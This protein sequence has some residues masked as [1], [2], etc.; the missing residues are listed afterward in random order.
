MPNVYGRLPHTEDARDFRARA[1]RP[2]TGAY[3]NLENRFGPPLDQG[4]LGSCVAFG[5]TAAAVYAQTVASRLPIP[6]SELFTYYAARIRA[7]YPADEDTGL[8]IR[9]GF[10]SLAKD[11]VAPASDWPYD[12]TRF[13]EDPP[14]SA[15]EDAELTEATVYGAVD[16]DGVDNMIASGWP[17]VIGFDVYESFEDQLTADTGVMSVPGAHE[18]QI[19]G[20]CVVLVSTPKIG[21][22]IASAVPDVLYRRARN[23]W[24]TGWGDEGWFWFPVAAMGHASDFWQVTTVGAV[25]PPAPPPVDTH[26]AAALELARVLHGSHGWVDG[27]HYGYAGKV[28]KAARRWLQS[29]EL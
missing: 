18:G 29:E 15:W 6:P 2:Y 1:S 21:S 4:A 24:G 20:H 25:A 10:A 7:G 22:E 14:P 3:V 17:V 23:S 11:G 26:S 19:G 8:Q 9:D 27:W 16:T 12:V 5:C 28:A 13:D